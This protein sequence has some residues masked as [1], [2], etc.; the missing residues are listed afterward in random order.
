[1]KK[2]KALLVS[3]FLMLLIYGLKS[4]RAD[5]QEG[6]VES[7]GPVEL[8]GPR[9]G[10]TIIGGEM[11]QTLRDEYDAVPFVT[12]FGWQ[13][14]WRYFS[15]DDG[16]SG[17]VE[18]IPLIGGVEQSLFLPSASLLMGIRSAKGLE[19]GLGPNLSVSGGSLVIAGGVTIASDYI[20]WPIN[21]A[22]LP[23]KTGLRFSILMGF[24]VKTSRSKE[25]RR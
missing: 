6:Q 16:P 17:L 2:L 14:E 13:F 15:I 3:L 4:V 5:A 1:M 19:F 12:Q 22:L 7:N 24:N 11:A 8:S 9:L 18:F 21:F 25:R 20:N 23:S 10:F